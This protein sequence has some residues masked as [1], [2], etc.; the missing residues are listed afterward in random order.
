LDIRIPQAFTAVQ[1]AS[2]KNVDKKNK[3][4]FSVGNQAS[5]PK[6][7]ST[8]QLQSIHPIFY[9]ENDEH[10]KKRSIT[11]GKT[12]LEE[13]KK[14][15]ASLLRGNISPSI[16]KNLE[17]L[18]IKKEDSEL[19]PELQLLLDEIETRAAVEMEKLKK[20]D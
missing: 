4:S 8:S 18:L 2:I 20:H 9:E 3:N 5:S 10:K 11:R 15:H 6:T 1:K 14:L 7:A 16:L 19:S 12:M 17:L 13:L